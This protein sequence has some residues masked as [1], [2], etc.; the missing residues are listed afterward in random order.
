MVFPPHHILTHH[1]LILLHL[2]RINSTHFYLLNQINSSS[3]LLHL[4]MSHFNL[5]KNHF[6]GTH[7]HSILHHRDSPNLILPLLLLPQFF[8]PLIYQIFNLSH[9]TLILITHQSSVPLQSHQGSTE[10]SSRSFKTFY[11]INN[12][13]KI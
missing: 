9:S 7:F 2:I 6:F 5:K 4:H 10:D 8:N 11:Q 3:Q 13:F 1:L 12:Y